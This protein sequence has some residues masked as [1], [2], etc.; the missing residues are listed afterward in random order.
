MGHPYSMG[1][2]RLKPGLYGLAYDMAKPYPDTN[3]AKRG[4]AP[5][6]RASG[7]T[8][9]AVSH[10]DFRSGGFA[11]WEGPTVNILHGIGPAM[12]RK[13]IGTH[14]SIDS[15]FWP[16]YSRAHS[17]CRHSAEIVPASLVGCA[18]RCAP[19]KLRWVTS[20]S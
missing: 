15:D 13:C 3:P 5:R 18:P 8:W 11:K 9:A 12:N 17:G 6:T 2:Q 14:F 1:R 4:S 16:Y 19:A 7:A 10:L 20:A